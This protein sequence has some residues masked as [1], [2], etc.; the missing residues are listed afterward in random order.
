MNENFYHLRI[1]FIDLH[2][3]MQ[4]GCRER[5]WPPIYIFEKVSILALLGKF[6]QLVERQRAMTVELITTAWKFNNFI[7]LNI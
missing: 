4:K 3:H 5:L 6:N 7:L 1:V 2:Q